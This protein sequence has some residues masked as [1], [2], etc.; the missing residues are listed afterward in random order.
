MALSVKSCPYLEDF[1]VMVVVQRLTVVNVTVITAEIDPTHLVDVQRR[2]N[3]KNRS[4]C[5]IGQSKS[6]L[7]WTGKGISPDMAGIWNLE[8]RR[9]SNFNNLAQ[10][11]FI[12]FE[13]PL[14]LYTVDCMKRISR[15]CE[16]VNWS[17]YCLWRF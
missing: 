14:C 1:L 8:E 15:T 4:I 11:R 9:I 2:K 6:L 10:T 3:C 16:H 12:Q 13:S 5:G 17:K 7:N